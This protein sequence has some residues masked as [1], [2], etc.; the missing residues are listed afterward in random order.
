[1]TFKEF[2]AMHRPPCRLDKYIQPGE[3]EKLLKYQGLGEYLLSVRIYYEIFGSI[4]VSP[5]I[6]ECGGVFHAGY[7]AGIR[8]ERDK[9][10]RKAADIDHAEIRTLARRCY[11]LIDH[12]A[13]TGSGA[14]LL[15]IIELLEKHS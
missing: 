3:A 15:H 5:E 13:Q 6:K 10:R 8:A 12:A 11:S 7:V 2:K 4:N 1:M 9:R 14:L